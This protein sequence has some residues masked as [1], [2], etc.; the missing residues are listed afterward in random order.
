MKKADG[1]DKMENIAVGI[2]SF[3]PEIN[4]LRD[5]INAVLNQVDHVYIFDNGSYNSEKLQDLVSNNSKVT[6]KLSLENKG[7]AYALNA[8]MN[9]AVVDGFEWMISMDQDSILQSDTVKQ[10]LEY[11]QKEDIAII[12]PYVI[13]SRRKYMKY[14][15]ENKTEEIDMCITSGS[16]TR[17]SVWKELGGFDE[18][19]F[20]D[21]IDNDYCK[22]VVL[23]NYKIVRVNTVLMNQEFGKIEPKSD[24]VCSFFV[25]LGEIL[26]NTNIQKF[27]YKKYV[28]PRR[29]YYTC[30]NV[31]Y[32]NRKYK[33]YGGIGYDN[34]HCSSFAGFLL[35]FCF[36]SI[37]RAQ[38]KKLTAKMCIKG[39]KDG[40]EKAN[41]T[42]P[43]II[44]K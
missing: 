14:E 30:R 20:I 31:L 9:M 28:D 34:Y 16:M 25:K 18:Y 26:H 5:N 33:L 42:V 41:K 6:L 4:R 43:I 38:K 21:L 10:F 44:K 2:V 37:A 11:S 29:V 13:D 39:L 24:R 7:L 23:H 35:F 32:L 8:L 15:Y 19:L 3:N 22:N 40:R 17:L 36:A 27:S 12:C 1:V